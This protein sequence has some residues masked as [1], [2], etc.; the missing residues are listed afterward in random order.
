MA[1]HLL[2]RQLEDELVQAQT[3]AAFWRSQV[4]MLSDEH[5]RSVAGES[6]HRT[7]GAVAAVRAAIIRVRDDGGPEGPLDRGGGSIGPK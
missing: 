3:S 4:P 5:L 7:L 2:L 1:K 6:L